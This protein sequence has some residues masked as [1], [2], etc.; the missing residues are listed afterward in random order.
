VPGQQ[1]RKG[2]VSGGRGLQ[3]LDCMAWSLLHGYDF[4]GRV[5]IT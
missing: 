2:L 1:A 4:P 5:E 3:T